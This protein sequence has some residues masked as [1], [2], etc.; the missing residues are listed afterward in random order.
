MQSLV[1]ALITSS[2]INIFMLLILLYL[3]IKNT[4]M[5]AEKAKAYIVVIVFTVIV[6]MTEI[7]TCELDML[8]AK[9]RIPNI[10]ANIVGFS[11]SACIPYV[12]SI[13]YDEKLY[14][15]IKYICIPVILNFALLVS[16]IWTG[17]IFYVSIDNQYI[18]GPLFGVYVITYILGFIL[19]MISNHKQSLQLQDT[20]R[21]FLMMLYA[22]ILIGTTAQ[23]IF[24]F[25]HSTWHCT[26]MSLVMYYLFQR[27]MQFRYDIVTTLLNRQMFDKK[28]DRLRKSENAGIILFDMN[29]FKQINDTYGHIKGDYYLNMAAMIIKN[30]FKDIGYS[31]R[32][33][34]DEFCVLTQNI[35][36]GTIQRCIEIIIQTLI[37]A[38]QTDST[39]PTVSYGY[40]IYRKNE[41][42]D[43]LLSFQEADEKMYIYKRN[44]RNDL[45]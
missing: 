42:S 37:K 25:I 9:F 39:I 21:T 41:Q 36:E 29:E 4:S 5:S 10:I 3:I 38:R 26:T 6:I 15:K 8:G 12:L 16:S 40:S 14:A 31:Y 30:S 2:V 32:I 44:S 17:W 19:L 35:S 27:E 28:L 34:G 1:L 22:V 18:R 13:V 43:I 11:L 45:I 23:V 33:G 20:E 24:P 7:A